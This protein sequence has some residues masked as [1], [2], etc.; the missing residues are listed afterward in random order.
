M[1]PV[2]RKENSMTMTTFGTG[3]YLHHLLSELEFM[4]YTP[5]YMAM[6]YLLWPYKVHL[7]ASKQ[8]YLVSGDG[9]CYQT[10]AINGINDACEDEN[11]NDDD[12]FISILITI[13]KAKQQLEASGSE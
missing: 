3:S 9:F 2:I 4:L 1:A 13:I 7:Y 5:L 10:G 12:K 6:D 8:K 11:E